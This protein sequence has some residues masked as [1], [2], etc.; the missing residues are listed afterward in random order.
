MMGDVAEG[1][2]I[3]GILKGIGLAFVETV[4]PLDHAKAVDTVKRAAEQPGV[5]AIIFK[6]PCI[7]KSKKKAALRVDQEICIGCTKCIREIGCPALVR[8]DG[9]V[10]IDA[11]LC[12]GCGLCSQICPVQAIGGVTHE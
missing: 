2:S 5:K 7:A 9:E 12:T 3:E 4:D 6:Y 8:L 1:I 10:R 11:G